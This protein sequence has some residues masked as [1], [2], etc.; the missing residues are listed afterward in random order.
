[1]AKKDKPESEPTA[2]PDPVA[3]EVAAPLM[4]S[5]PAAVIAQPERIQ[6]A[7]AV[8]PSCGHAAQLKI[9]DVFPV[10]GA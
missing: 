5:A 8:C 9:D 2:A 10:K 3:A 1:M 4:D 7:V 6:S